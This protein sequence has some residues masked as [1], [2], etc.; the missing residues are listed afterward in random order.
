MSPLTELVLVLTKDHKI[1]IKNPGVD[2]L[3]LHQLEIKYG[4][5]PPVAKRPPWDGGYLGEKRVEII[6]LEFLVKETVHIFG[7]PVRAP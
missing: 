6:G 7:S 4:G 3:D 5:R 1:H 2:L